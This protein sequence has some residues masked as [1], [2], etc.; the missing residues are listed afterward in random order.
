VK[1]NRGGVFLNRGVMNFLHY[2]IQ[3]FLLVCLANV[4]FWVIGFYTFINRP[5]ITFE[6]IFA[7]L[8]AIFSRPLGAIIFL[9]TWLIDGI[10]S[11]SLTYHFL[12]SF[13]F[14]RSIRFSNNLDWFHFF[15]M[16]H[17]FGVVLF[18]GSLYLCLKFIGRLQKYRSNSIF[19]LFFVALMLMSFDVINGT[20]DI[21]RRDNATFP[22]NVAGSPGFNLL[23][24]GLKLEKNGGI[25][26]IVDNQSIIKKFNVIQWALNHPNSSILFI[27][28]ESLGVPSSPHVRNYLNNLMIIEKYQTNFYEIKFRGSTTNGELRSLCGLDGSYAFMNSELGADCIPSQLSSIGWSATGYHG[29]TEKMFDRQFWWSSIGFDQ[30]FFIESNDIKAMP[31]CG[32][33]FRGA[34]DKNLLD[35]A[36]TQTLYPKSFVYVLT[37]N[38]HLPVISVSIPTSLI[39]ICS[40]GGLSENSCIH[41]TNLADILGYVAK[42][43]SKLS[44]PP[45]VI[46]V[47]DHA[48]P[49][50]GLRDRSN[51]QQ[52]VV[53]GFIL[54][55]RI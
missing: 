49:F 38:T 44:I 47:G 46:V 4:P 28:V 29:F 35:L 12:T 22:V 18:M 23:N 32:D 42:E 54:I 5:L 52:D 20:S 24:I 3:H 40:K 8:I 45:L 19:H 50:S 26:K 25:V 17:I 11:Q 31:R 14:L 10:V 15:S 51:F 30:K 16:W 9:V 37:L 13:E 33:V 27:V 36:I 34:C 6:S 55:P 2:F 21:W 41:M 1:I 48:P 43:V 7:F 39:E 53:P